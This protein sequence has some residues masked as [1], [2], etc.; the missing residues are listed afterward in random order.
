M[1]RARNWPGLVPAAAFLAGISLIGMTTASSPTSA[2]DKCLKLEAFSANIIGH[3]GSATVIPAAGFLK[4]QQLLQKTSTHE[5]V[6]ADAAYFDE[7]P[8]GSS[9]IV[10]AN[11]SCISA[12]W[13]TP[14][15]V[16]RATLKAMLLED[17]PQ[18]PVPAGEE[19]LAPG[20][21]RA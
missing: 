19:R 2:A 10:F 11:K 20:M 12:I 1:R 21:A 8:D 3:G 5:A 6:E 9:A 14:P 16:P 18:A 15:F 17:K 7:M 13:L 4:A